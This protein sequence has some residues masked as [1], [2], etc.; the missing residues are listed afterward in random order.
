M[1][2]DDPEVCLKCGS[3]INHVPYSFQGKV[4]HARCLLCNACGE[5]FS[6]SVLC[7]TTD[8]VKSSFTL[9]SSNQ[10]FLRAQSI[11]AYVTRTTQ[12]LACP[13]DDFSSWWDQ[14]LP[15]ECVLA[16]ICWLFNQKEG[17]HF[18]KCIAMVTPTTFIVWD[19]DWPPVVWWNLSSLVRSDWPP[20][21]SVDIHNT[22]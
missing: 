7:Y 14:V 5:I 17:F 2:T 21:C 3:H 8:S 18:W 4:F 9:L 22:D 20:R 11:C 13:D 6:P 1:N 12:W 10:H 16:C 19:N 15:S